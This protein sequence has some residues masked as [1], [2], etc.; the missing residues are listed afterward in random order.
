MSQLQQYP[1]QQVIIDSHIQVDT[2]NL[3]INPQAF[4]QLSQFANIMAGVKAP[5]RNTYKATQ[6]TV[7]RYVCKHCNGE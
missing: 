3:I 4:L 6:A 7:W 2:A 5:F 1:Q